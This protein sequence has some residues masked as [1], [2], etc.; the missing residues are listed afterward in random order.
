VTVKPHSKT[1]TTRQHLHTKHGFWERRS[2]LALCISVDLAEESRE[3]G[4]LEGKRMGGLLA[5]R[6]GDAGC[7]VR[8]P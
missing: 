2:E 4:A 7:R 3:G 8:L 5:S 6:G 1:R